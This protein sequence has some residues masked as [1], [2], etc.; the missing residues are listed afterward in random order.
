VLQFANASDGDF[1]CNGS[2]GIF[3]VTIHDR[4]AGKLLFAV[5]RYGVQTGISG[6]GSLLRLNFNAISAGLSH[7]NIT[8]AALVDN[9]PEKLGNISVTNSSIEVR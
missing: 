4:S 6:L 2:A 7:I 3:N 9:V 5:T 1:L 8:D